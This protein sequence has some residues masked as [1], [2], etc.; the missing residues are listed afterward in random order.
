MFHASLLGWQVGRLGFVNSLAGRRE[1]ARA[2]AGRH[3]V[4]WIWML[5]VVVRGFLLEF[6]T[7]QC[8]LQ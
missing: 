2:K 5:S 3:K 7:I 8:G 6:H 4:F 1:A